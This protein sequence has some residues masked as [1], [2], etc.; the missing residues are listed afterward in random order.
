MERALPVVQRER[1]EG[2][3]AAWLDA[4]PD[5]VVRLRPVLAIGLVGSL[6]QRSRFDGI[7]ARLSDIEHAIRTPD[8]AWCEQPPP[9]VIVVDHD[10][11]RSV[12]ARVEMYR[13]ALALAAGDLDGTVAH[14]ATAL[15]LAPADDDLTRAA[16]AALAGL[17]HWSGG[18]LDAAHAA[19][20]Q[21]VHG[22]ERAGFRA[23]VLGCCISLGD[24]RR[25]QGRLDDA[26]RTYQEAL[27]LTA[28]QPGAAPLR[29]TADMHVG[30]AEILLERN[31]LDAAADRL[32]T[33]DRLGEY[34]GLPQH[35]YRRRVIAARLREAEGDLDG[36]LVA[37][38]RGRA[39]LRR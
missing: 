15:A 13:T 37:A 4:V 25:T 1:R 9:G 27:D 11:Y 26:L 14:A 22:L 3:L 6:A 21:T 39:R 12:P 23:D 17:A 7:P 31:A 10:A 19:Y 20:T 33:C 8:G 38:R 34:N 28:P 32:E 36:A 30:I 5:D 35:P 24:I 16:A 18:D 2:E 29:G